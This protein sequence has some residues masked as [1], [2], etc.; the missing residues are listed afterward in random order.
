[1]TDVI[2]PSEPLFTSKV[3]SQKTG[4]PLRGSCMDLLTPTNKVK[5]KKFLKIGINLSLRVV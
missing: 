3:T 5:V 4:V 2:S 1:M